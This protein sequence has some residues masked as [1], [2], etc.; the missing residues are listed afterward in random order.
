MHSDILFYWIHLPT[1]FMETLW[2]SCFGEKKYTVEPTVLPNALPS[3]SLKYSDMCELFLDLFKCIIDIFLWLD[4]SWQA[5]KSAAV[6]Q[7]PCWAQ[8]SVSLCLHFRE[9]NATGKTSEGKPEN[10]WG[11]SL[12]KEKWKDHLPDLSSTQLF[13]G[14]S[15][16]SLMKNQIFFFIFSIRMPQC[17]EGKLNCLIFITLL[18]VLAQHCAWSYSTKR[19]LLHRR[20]MPGLL[21]TDSPDSSLSNGL[22]INLLAFSKANGSGSERTVLFSYPVD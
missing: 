8:L 18:A 7:F 9:S 19:Q 22:W 14:S 6:W 2:F 20:H 13:L 17:T 1:A 16:I 5:T 21:G 12:A 10:N 15:S 3:I 4:A 11:F